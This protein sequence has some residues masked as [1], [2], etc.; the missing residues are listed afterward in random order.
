MSTG[1]SKNVPH[2]DDFFLFFLLF[3]ESVMATKHCKYQ[4]KTT[5]FASPRDAPRF[6]KNVKKRSKKTSQ[7]HLKL[8]IGGLQNAPPKN[9]HEKSQ[10]QPQKCGKSLILGTPNFGEITGVGR[11]FRH[12]FGFG[13]LWG[14]PGAQNGPKTSSKPSQDPSKP[15]FLMIV[16]R[17]WNDF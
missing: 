4:Y 3:V 7:N 10:Q 14:S 15:R 5:F 2:F 6:T 1:L 13:R 11:T 12:F 9:D 17:S 16:D 8:V